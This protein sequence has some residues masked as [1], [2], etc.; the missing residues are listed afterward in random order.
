MFAEVPDKDGYTPEELRMIFRSVDI[1]KVRENSKLSF[2]QGRRKEYEKLLDPSYDGPEITQKE[3]DYLN[4]ELHIE[5]DKL[6]DKNMPTSWD[7]LRLH[8]LEQRDWKRYG[9][10]GIHSYDTEKLALDLQWGVLWAID[11]DEGAIK[12]KRGSR[13]DDPLI[14]S[15]QDKLLRGL[16]NARNSTE[17][18]AGISWI[19]SSAHSGTILNIPLQDIYWKRELRQDFLNL[20]HNF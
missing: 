16:R 14:S 5:E 17:I 9:Q 2:S 8:L 20:L 7:V 15:Y 1:K 6:R 11:F 4:P 18:L 19:L 10:I 13:K 3:L 12:T